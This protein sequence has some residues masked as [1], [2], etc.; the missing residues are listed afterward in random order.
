MQ[1]SNLKSFKMIA[2]LMLAG[3]LLAAPLLL[4]GAENEPAGQD[5][6]EQ[7]AVTQKP[8]HQTQEQA[9][10]QVQEGA[11]EA[12]SPAAQTPTTPDRSMNEFKPTEQIGAD[13]AVA[14]PIDI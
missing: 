4:A 7:P 12:T 9:Q 3:F 8:D 10:E 14:F 11:A 13:S 1:M 6:P 5:R 2:G